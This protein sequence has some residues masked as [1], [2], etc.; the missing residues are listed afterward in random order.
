[1]IPLKRGGSG[2]LEI[3]GGWAGVQHQEYG[4]G[5]V[6]YVGTTR[7]QEQIQ[8]NSCFSTFGSGYYGL[9][10]LGS[11][12]QNYRGAG[13]FVKWLEVLDNG[14]SFSP[15]VGFPKQQRW[16]TFGLNFTFGFGGN[17]AH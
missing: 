3:A 14:Q 11:R 13:V 15:R 16:I 7:V 8:C 1:M 12:N 9:V 5:K 2:R 17:A 6:S 4:V 10:Q